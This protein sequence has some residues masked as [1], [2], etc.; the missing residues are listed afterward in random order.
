MDN[1][2][3]NAGH[4][5]RL[6]DRFLKTG[7]DSLHDYEL[8]ELLLTYALPRRDIKPLAKELI[9]RFNGLSGVLDASSEE[10]GRVKGLSP[11]SGILIKLNKALTE[12]YMT[13]E[14]SSRDV[15]SSPQ[16]VLNFA[17]SKL[18][19][20]PNEV[21]LCI[22]LNTKNEVL[23][24][25]IIN[26]GTVD[27]AAVYPRR[28]IKEALD[29]HAAGLILMHNHPSGHCQPSPEDKALTDSI[30]S[31]AKTM[32]IRLLDHIIVGRLGHYSFA[33]KNLI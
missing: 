18:A 11:G 22:Y 23:K 7:G 16:T 26:Q 15:L 20:Q 28:I 29:C 25:S 8:L 19:G 13:N 6:K 10:L 9:K 21:F 30:I 33:E 2:E 1:R 5:Q 12:Y 31:V 32:D 27:K 14:M 24:H 17:K 3:L 4:R